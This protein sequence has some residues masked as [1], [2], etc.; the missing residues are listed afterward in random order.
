[1]TPREILSQVTVMHCKGTLFR[2]CGECRQPPRFIRLVIDL[3]GD[4]EAG[5]EMWACGECL[6][7]ITTS[8]DP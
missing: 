4:S 8:L 5:W 6:W 3:P 2:L 7:S 1:M